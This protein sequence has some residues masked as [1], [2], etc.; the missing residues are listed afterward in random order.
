M[1]PNAYYND[2]K[3]VAVVYYQPI[4]KYIK[5]GAIEHV[6]SCEHGISL[7]WVPEEHVQPLLSHLGG[8][9]GGKRTV[10]SLA[11]PAQVAHWRNGNGG[12]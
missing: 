1:I 7:A 10:V 5:V 4:P 3:L 6:F 12:R 2:D 11:N 8:C 9:C